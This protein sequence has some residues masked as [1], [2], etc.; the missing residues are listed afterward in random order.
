MADVIWDQIENNLDE[1]VTGEHI[2][3]AF[4]QTAYEQKYL[5]HI[6]RLKDFDERTKEANILPRI[7]KHLLKMARYV[8]RAILLVTYLMF[9]D[10]Y[11]KHAKVDDAGAKSKPAELS[12]DNIEAAKKEWENI[13]LSEAEDDM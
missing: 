1:W 10:L 7:R 2:S 8:T 12:Q 3:V 13:I 4:S 9:D 6:K 5:A 11:R